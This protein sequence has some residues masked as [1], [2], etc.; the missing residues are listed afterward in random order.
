MTPNPPRPAQI[1]D[2]QQASQAMLQVG[3]RCWETA[4]LQQHG[5]RMQQSVGLGDLLQHVG[6]MHCAIYERVYSPVETGLSGGVPT[7]R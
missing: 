1:L 3:G 5:H 2:A 4:R 7:T 6:A